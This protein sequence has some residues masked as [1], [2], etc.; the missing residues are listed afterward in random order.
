MIKNMYLILA[1]K[2]SFKTKYSTVAE[3]MAQQTRTFAIQARGP[4]SESPEPRETW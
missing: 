2:Y 3:E 1:W 4:K